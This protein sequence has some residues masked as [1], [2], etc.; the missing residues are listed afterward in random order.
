[1]MNCYSLKNKMVSRKV[2]SSRDKF[3]LLVTVEEEY[4]GVSIYKK[5]VKSSDKPIKVGLMI[6]TRRT[7]LE[8]SV[9]KL[10]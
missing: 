5:L 9:V 2:S 10:P 6:Q 8:R 4:G 7:A 3:V 1:M